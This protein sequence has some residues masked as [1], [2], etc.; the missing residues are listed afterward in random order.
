MNDI[1]MMILFVAVPAI[2]L[3][4][5]LLAF[6]RSE[7]G[8]EE[9]SA[10][11]SGGPDPEDASDPEETESSDAEQPSGSR[12]EDSDEMTNRQTRRAD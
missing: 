10:T 3:T 12:S 4:M 2:I 1:I 6:L 7:E 11:E 8:G 5:A 9:E